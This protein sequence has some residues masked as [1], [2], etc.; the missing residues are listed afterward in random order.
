MRVRKKV[1]STKRS[2]P[3]ASSLAYVNKLAAI[4]GIMTASAAVFG[5]AC[6]DP[7]PNTTGAGGS[8]LASSASSGGKGGMGGEDLNVVAGSV[9]IGSTVTSTAASSG[10]GP[11]CPK[12]DPA[13]GATKFAG[14]FGDA[15]VQTG[16]AIAFDK[17]GNILVAGSFGGTINLGGTT[18]SSAGGDDVFVAKFAPSGQLLWA[19]SFGDG[20]VQTA[21]GIGVDANGNV[22]VTGNFKGGINFGGG[23]LSATGTLFIDV[24]LAKLSTDGSHVWSKSFGDENVQN[25]RGLS[26]DTAGNVVIAGFFQNDINFGGSLLTSAGLYD[27]F[28]AK[29]NATGMHQWSRRFGDAAGDQNARA[30]AID[31]TGN[32]YLA[33]DA[34]SSIDVGGGAMSAAGK[35]SAFVAKLDPMGNAMWAKLS[36]GDAMSKGVANAISVGSNGDV[37]IG[38]SFRGAFDFGGTPVTNP[39]V[40]DAFV[41]VFTGAGMHLNT[42]T[43]GDLQSQSVTGVAI[44]ATGDVFVT[45]NFSGSIDLDTGEAKTSAGAFDGFIARLNDKGC[46][47][48]LRHFAGPM[49]QLTQGLALDPTTGGVAITG[50]FN[51]AVDFGTG[52]LTASGDDV[53][54]V[55]VN[56]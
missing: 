10:G 19:K 30:V 22:Y 24:F 38:G 13:G 37:A 20:N 9:S 35:P 33:G 25:V 6:G 15:S 49:A 54:I 41:T 27:M 47:T 31:G 32:V 4:T 11:T 18:L 39:G 23:T 51:G 56:P 8:G 42:K 55:S 7:T 46:P 3:S 14:A 50:S 16:S 17:S 44:G 34:A 40:D 26:V 21:A 53:F 2:T 48:W 29:F 45:G 52:M 43:F 12:L 1:P 28:V 5:G 36:A